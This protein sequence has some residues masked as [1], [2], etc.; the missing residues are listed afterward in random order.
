MAYEINII[1]LDV[2]FTIQINISCKAFLRSLHQVE[3]VAREARL[4]FAFHTLA[5]KA[6]ISVEDE[7]NIVNF[8]YSLQVDV[9]RNMEF[10]AIPN[11][12]GMFQFA[13]KIE[14]NM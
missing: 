5:I 11:F 4:I 2:L 10:F 13:T 3:P 14:E 9:K 7:L 8:P 12:G 1:L 6:G